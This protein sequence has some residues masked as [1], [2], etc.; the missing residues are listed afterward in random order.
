MRHL[1]DYLVPLLPQL[2][3]PGTTIGVV[4]AVATIPAMM[5][6]RGTFGYL[7]FYLLNWVAVRAIMD[8][9]TKLFA[10]LQNLSLNFF[11]TSSTGDLISRISNDTA[12]LHKII[13]NTFP[14]LVRGPIAVLGLVILL[15]T[16]Q[17]K[18]TLVSLVVIPICIVPIVI[19]GRKVRKSS[20]AIQDNF[21][22]L[23]N[24][25]QEAFTGTRIVKA[26]NLEQTML[27]RFRASS[28]VFTSH[29]MRV[30]RSLEIPG[31]LIEFMGS[32]GI[33]LV[34]LYVALVDRKTPGDFFQFVLSI[35]ALY[36]PIK[37]LSRVPGQ[38]EQARASSQRVFELLD[39]QSTVE[40]PRQPLLFRAEKTDIQFDGID[41]AY[42]DRLALRDIHLTVRAGQLVAL[43]GSSGAGKTTL[44][45][46]LLRFY[47][48]QRGAVLINGTDIRQLATRDLRNHIALVTQEVIL[49]NDTFRQNIALGRLGATDAEIEEAARHAHAHEFILEK[50]RGACRTRTLFISICTP[51]IRCSMAPAGWT[52]LMDKAHELKFPALAITDHGVLY[53]AIDFYPGGRGKRASSPS[54]AA[55]FM[56]RRAAASKRKPAAADAMFIII[57]CCWRRTRPATRISSSSP[58]PRI[59]KAII[60]SRASTRKFSPRTR[61]G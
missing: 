19:Y 27:E 34:L 48:P 59:S 37:E 54:S 11:H 23:T 16:Q 7:N 4:L 2:K 61:K 20:Q 18:L 6:L 13:S 56:S 60:T 38:L 1:A 53:G 57:S 28:R 3:S 21:A 17:P 35:L 49:F 40:E 26:Y 46:L 45:N 32:I 36:Q 43:V 15:L 5:L 25:M 9:R 58:P 55:R 52:G 39:T 50:P 41:F 44:T 33:A 29:F 8:L 24:L 14:A 42:G 47:D 30:V 10:H 51:S 31:V 12:T 22:E